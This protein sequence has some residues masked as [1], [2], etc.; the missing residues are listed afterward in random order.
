MICDYAIAVDELQI[1]RAKLYNAERSDFDAA[2][3]YD[4][5]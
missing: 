4:L 5:I 2:Y 1:L 3:I